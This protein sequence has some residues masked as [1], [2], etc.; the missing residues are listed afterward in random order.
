M[1]I[2]RTWIESQMRLKT[3]QIGALILETRPFIAKKP[4][5]EFVISRTLSFDWVFLKL[6][7][8][9]DMNVISDDFET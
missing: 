6:A 8:K 3:G 9:G 7:V 4:L 2:S 5:F 1:Q